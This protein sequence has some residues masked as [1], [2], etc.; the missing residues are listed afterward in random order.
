MIITK[1]AIERRTFLRGVGATVALPFLDAMVPALKGAQLAKPVPRL[2]FFYT[3]NGVV[4]SSFHPAGDGGTGFTL[5]RVLAPLEPVR[6]HINVL[7]GLSNVAAGKNGA[8]HTNAHSGWL[9]GVASKKTEGSDIRVAKTLDQYAA[10]RLGAT[11]MLRSLE[12]TTESNIVAGLCEF[13]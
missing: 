3:P 8:G 5:P 13:G 10:D 11:T 12:L 6:E 4:P 7:T 2:G 1:K 9:N